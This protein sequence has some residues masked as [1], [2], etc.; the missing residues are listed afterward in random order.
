MAES[1]NPV[2]AEDAIAPY[3][4]LVTDV[5]NAEAAAEAGLIH[6]GYV[7]Y[8]K[9]LRNL[10]ARSDMESHADRIAR[11]TG[12]VVGTAGTAGAVK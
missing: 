6:A 2:T 5:A 10:E 11:E 12:G 7:D 1:Y 4:P 8:D 9:A 3:E